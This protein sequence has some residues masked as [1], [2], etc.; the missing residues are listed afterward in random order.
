MDNMK[1]YE[2]IR[3]VP[4]EAK[5]TISAGR[6]NGMTDINPMWRIKALTEQFGVCG[7]GWYFECTKQWI[8]EVGDER[9]ACVNINLYIKV[10]GEW[11]KPIFGT[12]GSKLST[13]E[14]SGVYVSDECYKMATTDAISVA[15]KSLG[16]GADVYWDKDRTKY[17]PVTQEQKEEAED[18][19]KTKKIENMKISSV[20]ADVLH[21]RCKDEGVDEGKI[22]TLYKVSDFSELTEKQFRN[23]SDFWQKIKEK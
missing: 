4:E 1:I 2:A 10:D 12:G 9:V 23:I 18:T 13:V 8:E 15:C 5:K 11:S 6:L 14:R 21:K 17:S 19:E 16:M 7:I 22:L 20:K 3:T